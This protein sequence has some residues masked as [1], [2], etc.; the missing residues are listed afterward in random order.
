MVRKPSQA[1]SSSVVLAKVVPLA[2][3]EHAVAMFCWFC[4]YSTARQAGTLEQLP[5]LWHS[6]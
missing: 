1:C 3:D 2:G 5:W 6:P 4:K